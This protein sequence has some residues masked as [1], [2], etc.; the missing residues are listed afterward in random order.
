MREAIGNTPLVPLRRMVTP[1]MA[2]ILV[3]LEYCNP[4][5][6]HK[7]RMALALIEEAEKRG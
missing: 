1:D 2:R 4:T 6:S 7:D 3:K 5:G